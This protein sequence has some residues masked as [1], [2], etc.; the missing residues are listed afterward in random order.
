MLIFKKYRDYDEERKFLLSEI[1]N[2]LN[3]DINDLEIFHIYIFEKND[4]EEE[5]AKKIFDERY[6]S[7]TSLPEE[8]LIIKDNAGQYNQVEDLTKKYVN[9][10]LNIDTDLRYAKGYKFDLVN[11]E[12]IERIKK[13]L[14][15]DVIQKELDLEEIHFSYELSDDREV[16]EVEGFND[17]NGQELAQ[18]QE[19]FGLDLDD[20]KFIQEHFKKEGR[21]PRYSELKMLATYWSDHCRHT[22]FL[23]NIENVTIEEGKYKEP[24]LAS[25]ESYLETRKATYTDKV[26]P[27]SLMDLATINMKNLKKSGNL[28]DMEVSDEVNACSIEV[29]IE[30]DGKKERWL[31]MFKNETHNHPTEIEPYGGAHTCIGGG[32]RDPLS[33]RSQ[34]IQGIRIVGAG[35]PLTSFDDTLD[36]KLSQRYIALNAMNGF[37]DYANQIGSPV[38]IVREFYD[39]GFTA[40]RM[41]LGALTAAV[42]KDH[43][44]REKPLPGDYILLL[45]APTGR[46]GL[47]AAVGSSS[48]QT[49]KSLTKAGAEVQK[50]NP[51]EERKI[52]KLFM[53]KEASKLIKKSNDFGAGGVSVAIGEL[54]DGLDI[55]LDE[56]Y[57]KYPGLNGYEIALSESQ[58]RMAVVIAEKDLEEFVSYCDEEDLRYALVARVT[59]DNRLVMHHKGKVVLDLSRELLNSNGAKKYANLVVETDEKDNDF[60]EEIL[61]LN[62]AITP[63]LSQNFDQTLGRNKVFM[64]YGGK[65]QLTQQF[66]S[67]VKFPVEKTTAVSVMAYGYFPQLAKKSAYH[68]GYYAVLQSVLNNM[69]ITGKYEDIRL[70]MQEFF[71]S[72]K[73]DDRRFGLPFAALLGAYEV[74]DKLSIPAIGGKDSMSGSFKDIDVPP[75]LVSFAVNTSTVDRVVSRELKGLGNKLVLTRVDV[76]DKGLIDFASFKDCMKE[77]K[78]LHETGKV[79]SASSISEYGLEFTLDDMSLGNSIGYEL[80]T[81][82]TD[83][84][85]PGNLVFEVASDLDLDEKYFQVIGQTTELTD[86]T[87][88]ANERLEDIIR[89]YEDVV[90]TRSGLMLEEEHVVLED[91]APDNKRALVLVVEGSTGEYDLEWALENAGFKTDH[92]LV[93]TSSNEKYLESLE[94]LAKKIDSVSIL[95]IPHGDYQASVIRNISGVIRDILEDE[96]VRKAIDRLVERKG[97]VL[98]IGAGMAGLIDA[99]LFGKIGDKLVFR[100]NENNKYISTMLDLVSHSNS[101]LSDGYYEYSAPISGRMI[102]LECP[103]K[104]ALEKEVD[105]LSYNKKNILE[106]DSGIDSI[107]S[108]C[109]HIVGIRSNIERMGKDLYKNIEIEGQPR[110]FEVLRSHFK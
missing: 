17:L 39:E 71:P 61:K 86:I 52:I 10:I 68:G 12:D 9:N 34:V 82:I 79:L 29:D 46:D 63:N 48:V 14:L 8:V 43:V 40:K 105:I 84:F 100:T 4:R 91:L 32:I 70:T 45:G 18:Q 51:F 53:R 47:G 15:N 11:K 35:N 26:K 88:M 97:F 83:S 58:E 56:V 75:T 60:D 54:A 30:V 55:N 72:I 81:D 31:H 21:N 44:T 37:S 13:Y 27:V 89:V 41:E 36:G 22:T 62:K 102:T 94:E 85:L 25:Y 103:D 6:G 28:S 110:H 107:A 57:T 3:I 80:E 38:G 50:G 104:D 7:L 24:I 96:K 33:G 76:D 93:K 87:L 5:I 49:D 78:G 65:N 99:G 108:K 77:F 1:K 74:M 106:K 95:A 20:L 59:D 42:K 90:D 69:A 64:E 67:V 109:G 66:A 101:Y 73:G 19:A 92:Y 16:E 2:F 98:G 23:T